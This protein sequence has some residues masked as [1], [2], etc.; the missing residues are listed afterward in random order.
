FEGARTRGYPMPPLRSTD[1]YDKMTAVA[2]GLGWH[3]FP[4]PAAINSRLYQGRS[5]CMYHGYCLGAGCPVDAKNSTAVT[6]IP[7][8]MATKHRKVVTRAIATT[9]EVDGEGRVAGVNYV[10]DGEEFF[11]PARVMLLSS[12][13]YE[14]ARLLLV[15]KSKA[16][17][18]GLGN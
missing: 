5:G 17:P 9:F 1:F 18:N 11:Q 4:G 8:A 2:K 13:V 3:P 6:T 12:Y 16:F 15:S 14:N 7:R 10:V